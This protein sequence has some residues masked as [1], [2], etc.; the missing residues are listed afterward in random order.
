MAC[1]QAFISTVENGSQI[2]AAN[3][4]HQTNA[5]INKKIARLEAKLGAQL[6]ERDNKSSTLTALGERYYHA[7]KELLEKLSDIH[8]IA[9][10]NQTKPAGRLMI[11][12]SRSIAQAYI[13]L[14]LAQFHMRYPDIFLVLDI[15]EI[16]AGHVPGKQDILIAPDRVSHEDL[17]KEKLFVT[18]DILCATPR[19]LKK[20]AKPKRLSDLHQL[21]YIGHCSRRPINTITLSDNKK[22]EIAQPLIRT[23]DDLTAIQIALQHLGFLYTK[24]HQVK[25]LL[26]SGKLVEI[27]P[28]LNKAQTN[29]A[30]HYH[31]KTYLNNKIKAFLDFYSTI[32]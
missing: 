25:H 24:E 28:H 13:I 15:A 1:A 22:I 6:I 7:Y 31:H 19:Y 20:H 26:D 2:A 10:E 27:L 14:H 29:I 11:T 8:G 5:A 9:Q 23:N 3:K 30:I 4:L 21:D 12:L 18:R 17:V 16:T 32:K